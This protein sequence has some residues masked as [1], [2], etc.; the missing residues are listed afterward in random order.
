MI[1][2]GTPFPISTYKDDYPEY[3]SMFFRHRRMDKSYPPHLHDYFEIEI[4]VSGKAEELL[5]G[6]PIH[7]E[8]GSAHIL[9]TT[10]VHDITVIE[11]LDMYKFMINPN[12]NED[13]IVR[14]IIDNIGAVKF[15][16]E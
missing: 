1:K 2:T 7:L 16:R 8:S 14:A 6:I 3:K 9:S 5:N 15:C 12:N 13:D 4:V 10:D 11:P